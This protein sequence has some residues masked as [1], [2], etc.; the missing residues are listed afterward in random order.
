MDAAPILLIT[1]EK[2]VRVSIN[3][4]ELPPKQVHVAA[5]SAH[6]VKSFARKSS[7]CYIASLCEARSGSSDI[8]VRV[9]HNAM[10]VM[11]KGKPNEHVLANPFNI[12]CIYNVVS[13]LIKCSNP[14][15]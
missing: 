5:P 11:P 12:G 1:H 15:T 9:R 6:A 13:G 8:Q 2:L 3:L 7:E 4:F 10:P 14:V